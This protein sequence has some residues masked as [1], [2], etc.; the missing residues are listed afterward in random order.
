MCVCVRGCASSEKRGREGAEKEE[1]SER[2]QES[3]QAPDSQFSSKRI[4]PL[5]VA[6]RQPVWLA[7]CCH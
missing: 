4:T 5:P 3:K 6:A 7:G 2:G 1:E